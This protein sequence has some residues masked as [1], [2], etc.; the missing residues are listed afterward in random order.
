MLHLRMFSIIVYT[1][2]LLLR[3]SRAITVVYLI[4][5]DIYISGADKDRMRTMM[6]SGGNLLDARGKASIGVPISSVLYGVGEHQS[7]MDVTF[8][9]VLHRCVIMSAL[10]SVCLARDDTLSPE[11]QE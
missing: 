8:A 2:Y 3:L 7:P 4:S 1:A 9:H 10:S 6:P 11:R 5:R